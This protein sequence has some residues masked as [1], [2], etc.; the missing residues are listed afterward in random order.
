MRLARLV[1]GF[2]SAA[3]IAAVLSE[4]ASSGAGI[5]WASTSPASGPI[6]FVQTNSAQCPSV[7][8]CGVTLAGTVAGNF[9]PVLITT[10]NFTAAPNITGVATD[11]TTTCSHAAN[12]FS[13]VF[14]SSQFLTSDIWYCPNNAA[15]GSIT[16]TATADRTS[17]TFAVVLGEFS[18][19]STSSPDIGVGSTNTTTGSFTTFSAVT[20]GNLTQTNQLTV[21]VI[22]VL[23]VAATSWGPNQNPFASLVDDTYKLIN[24]SGATTTDTYNFPAGNTGACMS[25]AVFSHP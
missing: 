22:R 17:P 8:T 21:S 18:G 19:V 10:I 20:G 7:L 12:T 23:T 11:N 1:I 25:I 4:P 9:I 15:G 5:F 13:T 3:V 16:V 24:S 14:A 2:L 6:H